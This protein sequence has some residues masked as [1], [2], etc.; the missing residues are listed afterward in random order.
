MGKE[1]KKNPRDLPP[2]R[3]RHPTT[4]EWIEV[5][6]SRDVLIRG[7]V[8]EE[9][10]KLPGHFSWY[11][12]LRDEA[13]DVLREARYEEYCRDEDLYID[14]KREFE[15]EKNKETEIKMRVKAHPRM[16]AAFQARNEAEK[17]LKHLESILQQLVEKRNALQMLVDWKTTEMRTGVGY[18]D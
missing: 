7:E 1:D 11:M 17:T 8:P 16:R 14:L 10:E 5:N 18:N 4:K 2:I 15:G 12:T 6:Y 9:V 13:Q 3:V